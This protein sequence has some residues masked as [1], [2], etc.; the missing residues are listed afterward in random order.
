MEV[1][2]PADLWDT[3]ITPEGVVANWFYREGATVEAG[4]T[5]AEILVEKSAYEVSAPASG[6]LR[7]IA[8][9]DAVVTPGTVI[10][11]IA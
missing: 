9:A 2:I 1:R 11:E 3:G 7:I 5:L 6:R 8:P 10:A 4:A